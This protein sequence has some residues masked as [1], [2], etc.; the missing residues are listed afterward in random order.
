[1]IGKGG[2]SYITRCHVCR[3]RK[4]KV[5]VRRCLWADSKLT[6]YVGQCD[7]QLPSCQRCATAGLLCTG[8]ERSLEFAFFD[9]QFKPKP[10]GQNP[11]DEISLG[12]KSSQTLPRDQNEI[13][14][15]GQQDARSITTYMV[16][17]YVNHTLTASQYKI[18][19]VAILQEYYVPDL[20]NVIRQGESI[21][22][23]WIFTACELSSLEGSDMLGDAL[24]AMSL[25][26]VGGD[27]QDQDISISGLRY[28][29][30]AL[31]RLRAALG[32]KVALDPH[33]VDIS[34]VTCLVCAMYEVRLSTRER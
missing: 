15:S 27:R 10:K 24:L 17:H 3:R 5:R 12:S 19:F 18:G 4:V 6:I 7:G 14:V 31:N 25:T 22:S 23:S 20:P 26:L 13:A 1:M 16:Q 9:G 11:T 32:F 21:C 8:Y 29:L 2:R 34:L 28:Y 33:H 30:R